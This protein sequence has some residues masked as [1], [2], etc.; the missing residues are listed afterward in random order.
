MFSEPPEQHDWQ[1][2]LYRQHAS[3]VQ[4]GFTA[5]CCASG[6]GGGGAGEAV[7]GGNGELSGG[8]DGGGGG[9]G[10]GNGGNVMGGGDGLVGGDGLG[11]GE[12]EVRSATQMWSCAWSPH[13][14]PVEPELQKVWIDGWLHQLPFQL[15]PQPLTVHATPR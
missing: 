12:G 10:G 7:G 2:G 5:H 13:A 1:P 4:T 3:L 9:G 15:Q 6:T 11:G 14:V 8:G